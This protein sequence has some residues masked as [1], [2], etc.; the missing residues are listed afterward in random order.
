MSCHCLA[1]ISSSVFLL[2]GTWWSLGHSTGGGDDRLVGEEKLSLLVLQYWPCLLMFLKLLDPK[3]PLLVL[4]DTEPGLLCPG[5]D[6]GGGRDGSCLIGL[7]LAIFDLLNLKDNFEHVR[8]LS[9]CDLLVKPL[10]W[11]ISLCDS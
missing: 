2:A 5:S 6:T 10:L 9:I 1:Y 3:L 4:L 7:L 8:N 11:S